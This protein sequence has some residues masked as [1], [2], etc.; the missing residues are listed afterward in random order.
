M[1]DPTPRVPTNLVDIFTFFDVKEICQ[2]TKF[3]F[4]HY[5]MVFLIGD[6]FL[7]KHRNDTLIFSLCYLRTLF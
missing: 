3:S 2:L 1:G 6:G 5:T 7:S 4:K